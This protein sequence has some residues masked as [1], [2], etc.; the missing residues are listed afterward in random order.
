[1]W[2]HFEFAAS[3]MSGKLIFNLIKIR[4]SIRSPVFDIENWGADGRSNFN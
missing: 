2:K 4:P 3:K 1:M